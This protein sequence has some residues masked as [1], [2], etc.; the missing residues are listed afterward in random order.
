MAYLK[1]KKKTY[2]FSLA[3]LIHHI[4]DIRNLERIR[5]VTSHPCDITDELINEHLRNK[6][7]MPYLHLPVQSGSNKILKKMNRNYSRE[8]YIELI[9]KIR[10][11]RNDMA[12]SSDFIVGFPGETDKDFWD[13]IQLV[14]EIN[15]ASSYSFKYSSRPG[16]PASLKANTVN[17]NVK[18]RRLHILQ[19]ILDKQQKDFNK[20]F[21]GEKLSVLF[22]KKG[23]NKNQ[24]VGKSEYLQPVH[25][26]TNESIIGKIAKVNINRKGSFSLHGELIS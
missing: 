1:Q 16:T 23:K 13:T 4:S 5:Y 12:I 19:K 20:S 25:V 18:T 10:H 2:Q 6:K 15:F 9:N 7:L 21:V 11:V 17:D 24:F 14:K 26:I 3:N 22:E 8:S